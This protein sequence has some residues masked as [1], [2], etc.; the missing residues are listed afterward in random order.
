MN[1]M[2]RRC[3]PGLGP[4]CSCCCQCWLCWHWLAFRFS[5]RRIRAGPSTKTRFLPPPGRSPRRPP[6]KG[7]RSP[8]PLRR[9]W[10][11]QLVEAGWHIFV[12]FS[13]SNSQSDTG[14]S[15]GGVAGSANDGGT[16]GRVAQA[17]AHPRGRASRAAQQPG[18]C[19]A[20]LVRRWRRV[21]A[22]GADPDR[23]ARPRGDLGGRRDVQAAPQ[24]RDARSPRIS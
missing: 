12:G 9:R 20:R 21:L 16:A 14:S 23:D 2:R 18:R 15:S 3:G 19:E 7:R 1:G 4:D 11:D 13:G 24:A 6:Q 22:A 17:T 8:R 10:R 5:L